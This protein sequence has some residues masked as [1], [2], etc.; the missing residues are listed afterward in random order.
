MKF[1]LQFTVILISSLILQLFLPWLIVAIVAMAAGYLLSTEK[2]WHN[3]LAGF[4]AIVVL[5]TVAAMFFN[6]WGG[7]LIAGRLGR[8]FGLP[9]PGVT[10][11]LISGMIGGIAGGLGAL[12]G[13]AL[14]DY[15]AKN[16]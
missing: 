2:G 12:T 5:W 4:L 8:Q 10:L 1:L 6:F 7:S 13:G 16:A 9:A 14:K 3:F 11:P 15:F